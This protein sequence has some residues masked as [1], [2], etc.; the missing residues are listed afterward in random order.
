MEEKLLG[1]GFALF[2]TFNILRRL[3]R[4]H[5]IARIH[6]LPWHGDFEGVGLGHGGSCEAGVLNCGH[7]MDHVE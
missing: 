6:C 2:Q 7:G 3:G 4:V 1:K 5:G